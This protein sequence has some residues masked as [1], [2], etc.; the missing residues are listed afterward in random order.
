MKLPKVAYTQM[1]RICYDKPESEVKTVARALG[2]RGTF[3]AKEVGI[4]TFD[5]YKEREVS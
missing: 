1:R 4:K 5:Y 3:S 2:L